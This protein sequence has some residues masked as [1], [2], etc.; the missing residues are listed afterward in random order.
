MGVVRLLR[1]LYLPKHKGEVIM[2]KLPTIRL[3]NVKSDEYVHAVSVIE[4]MIEHGELTDSVGKYKATIVSN[5]YGAWFVWE[6]KT[7]YSIQK[8]YNE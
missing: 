6:T 4:W 2:N 5:A 3:Y 1:T 7:G 8:A